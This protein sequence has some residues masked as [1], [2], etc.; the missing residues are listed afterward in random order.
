LLASKHA[1]GLDVGC[2]MGRLLFLIGHFSSQVYPDTGAV[3]R[4]R[5]KTLTTSVGYAMLQD[6][7]KNDSR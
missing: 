5:K 2:A 6:E 3:S 1:F 7:M 4:D